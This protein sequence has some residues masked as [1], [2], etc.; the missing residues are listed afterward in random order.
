MKLNWPTESP[1]RVEILPLIDIVFLLL[2]FFIY[3]MLS[4]TVNRGVDVDLPEASTAE[5]RKE[6]SICITIRGNGALSIDKQSLDWTDLSGQ[7]RARRA[8]CDHMPLF[9]RADRSVPYE[10][11]F[12]VL[13]LARGA[14]FY[15]ISLMAEAVP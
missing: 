8:S 1:P 14:G 2:V 6:E 4:M 5:T 10:K 3:A 15:D 9:I 7:L 13:D 11:V 12:K